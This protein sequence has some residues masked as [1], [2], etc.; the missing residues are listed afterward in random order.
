VQADTSCVSRERTL[1]KIMEAFAE[2]VAVGDFT[3]AE[4]WLAVARFSQ[5]RSAGVD[6]LAR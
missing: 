6:A 2:A 5:D 3:K 4:G 1:E